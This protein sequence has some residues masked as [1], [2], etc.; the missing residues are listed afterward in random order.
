MLQ[1]MSIVTFVSEAYSLI[2]ETSMCFV[3]QEDSYGHPCIQ[4]W[5]TMI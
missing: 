3:L 4:T 1:T 5:E 2:L